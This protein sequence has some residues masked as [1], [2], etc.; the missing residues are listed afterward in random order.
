M[1]MPPSVHSGIG[2]VPALYQHGSGPV[3]GRGGELHKE[4]APH[5]CT[6]FVFTPLES[7][8]GEEI[9]G[10]IERAIGT[11]LGTSKNRSH[12]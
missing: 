5:Q 10:D 1:K 7:L 2:G 11:P 3:K 8:V 12:P 6:L 4:S 9:G